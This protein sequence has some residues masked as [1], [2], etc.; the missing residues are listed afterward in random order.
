[1]DE[2]EEMVEMKAIDIPDRLDL[3]LSLDAQFFR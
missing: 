2:G 1:M 3:L